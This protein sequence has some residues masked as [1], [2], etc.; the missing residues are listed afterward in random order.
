MTHAEARAVVVDLAYDRADLGALLTASKG[1]GYRPYI[2][3][4]V[5]LLT[6]KNTKRVTKAGEV[7]F[8][9]ATKEA[10]EN[11]LKL[12]AVQD[13]SISQI[14]ASWTVDAVRALT[15]V[16]KSQIYSGSVP[17]RAVL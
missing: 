16:V 15:P 11:L 13:L 17:V 10:A 3:A 7:N 4:A 8:T 12:Q 9:E 1:D 5:V 2:V 14:P 6:S